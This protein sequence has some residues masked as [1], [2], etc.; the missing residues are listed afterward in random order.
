MAMAP[1]ALPACGKCRRLVPKEKPPGCVL[2]RHKEDLPLYAAPFFDLYADG[3]EPDSFHNLWLGTSCRTALLSSRPRLGIPGTSEGHK[4]TL[5]HQLPAL[6]RR[7][8]DVAAAD[9]S[10]GRWEPTARQ[11]PPPALQETTHTLL[12][13]AFASEA[14]R[15]GALVA[16]GAA[17]SGAPTRE[18]IALG[19]GFLACALRAVA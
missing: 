8:S 1:A 17:P 9:L 18:V 12:R 4:L 14:D 7:S 5:E 3:Q 13:P 10:A 15:Y 19:L 6:P 2:Y 16:P 11:P